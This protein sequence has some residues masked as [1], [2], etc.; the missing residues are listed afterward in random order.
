[1]GL[2]LHDKAYDI[3]Y[4]EVSRTNLFC[5]SGIPETA[6]YLQVQYYGYRNY[7]PTQN[8]FKSS[9]HFQKVFGLSQS[10]MEQ[11]CLDKG[12][13][14]P[15]W[16]TVSHVLRPTFCVPRFFPGTN[17]PTNCPAPLK[18]VSYCFYKVRQNVN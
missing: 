8:S 5:G 16:L 1:M 14:G 6:T 17:C 15:C 13:E 11:F 2:V 10:A 18:T 4:K 7:A 9:K 12:V 3:V